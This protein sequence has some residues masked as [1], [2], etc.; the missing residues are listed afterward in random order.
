MGNIMKNFLDRAK[1]RY[2]NF[3]N[4]DNKED[5]LNGQ[6]IYFRKS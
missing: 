3:L 1:N 4:I 2:Y 6:A 5:C